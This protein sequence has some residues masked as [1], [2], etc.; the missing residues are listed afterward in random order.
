MSTYKAGMANGQS[1]MLA[2]ISLQPVCQACSNHNPV[3]QDIF[4]Y[5]KASW[6]RG[7]EGL[8][9]ELMN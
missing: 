7:K 6:E 8:T 5:L 1:V 4:L 2:N 9:I 3:Y